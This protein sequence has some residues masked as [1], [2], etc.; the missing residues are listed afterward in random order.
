MSDSDLDKRSYEILGHILIALKSFEGKYDKKLNFSKLARYFRLNERDADYLAEFIVKFQE[1][2]K[3]FSKIFCKYKLN[4]K[5]ENGKIYVT[6]EIKDDVVPKT[7]HL[8]QEHANWLSDLIYSFQ[9]VKKGKGFDLS[10]KNVDIV[11][12]IRLLMKSHPYLFYKNGGDLVY[13]SRL[14]SELGNAIL[15]CK[16]LNKQF[17]NRKINECEIRID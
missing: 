14:G 16:K 9:H 6:A 8:E 2:F 11:R 7:I 3:D 4:K 12:K 1:E 17:V 5:Y 13:P 10:N 15:S